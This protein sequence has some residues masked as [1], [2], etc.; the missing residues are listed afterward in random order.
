MDSLC[1]RF[2]KSMIF[3][4]HDT[5]RFVLGEICAALKSIHDLGLA[6]ND[7]KPENVLITEV[8]HIKVFSSDFAF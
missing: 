6:F 7:L 2:S 5:F 4:V 3:F 8:G 1:A